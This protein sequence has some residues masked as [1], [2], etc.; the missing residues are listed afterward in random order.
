[1][2][3]PVE[4]AQAVQFV[5]PATDCHSYTSSA[6]EYKSYSNYVP[7]TTTADV[8]AKYT[9]IELF[10]EEIRKY[11][12]APVAGTSGIP[13]PT[14]V[15]AESQSASSNRDRVLTLDVSSPENTNSYGAAGIYKPY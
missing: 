11:T 10:L 4:S 15:S 3:K 1:M 14:T 2:E 8:S 9:E 12:N 6:Y 5:P 7:T 13:Q